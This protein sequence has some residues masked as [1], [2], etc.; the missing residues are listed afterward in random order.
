MNPQSENKNFVMLPRLIRDLYSQD[1][2]NFNQY[3]VLIWIWL[4][5]NP[6]NGS[7]LTSPKSLM[8]DFPG[9]FSYETMRQILADLRRSQLVYYDNRKGKRGSFNIYPVNFQRTNSFIQAWDYLQGVAELESISQPEDNVAPDLNHNSDTENHIS[10]TPNNQMDKQLAATP[11]QPEITIPYKDKDDERDTLN[12]VDTSLPFKEKRAS[13]KPS[14]PIPVDTFV[15]KT[16][17]EDLCHRAAQWLR[18]TD[19]QP[20]L[21]LLHQYKAFYIGKAWGIMRVDCKKPIENKGAY[22]TALIRKLYEDD[23]K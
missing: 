6:V 3:T 17:D 18:E 5:T 19:M 4:N 11:N 15:A 10:E 1:K 16:E 20:I 22:F 21:K 2:L 7:Y 23:H 12:I 13:S 9:H 8:E 14:I